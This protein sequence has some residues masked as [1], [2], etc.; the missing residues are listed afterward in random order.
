MLYPRGKERKG[1]RHTRKQ[2]AA[3]INLSTCNSE[4]SK[5]GGRDRCQ[6]AVEGADGSALGGHDDDITKR[7]C[8]KI[9][10][11]RPRKT[12]PRRASPSH[13]CYCDDA[14]SFV[15]Q[16]KSQKTRLEQAS[17]RHST[18]KNTYFKAELDS[19]SAYCNKKTQ[20]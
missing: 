16:Q 12:P 10:R 9:G 7:A 8:R 5:T 19:T 3:H 4:G 1:T 14:K 15:Q 18:Y 20:S 13:G 6:R 2:Q 17:S 11:C